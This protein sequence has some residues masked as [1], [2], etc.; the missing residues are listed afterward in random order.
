MIKTP[1]PFALLFL[2][3]CGSDPLPST[4]TGESNSTSPDTEETGETTPPDENGETTPP[5]ASISTG[6]TGLV[7]HSTESPAVL[8]D[9]VT[10]MFETPSTLTVSLRDTSLQD[11]AAPLIAEVS[12]TGVNALPIE[13]QLD[14]SGISLTPGRTYSLSAHVDLDQSGDVSGGDLLNTWSH[15]ISQAAI[16]QLDGSAEGVFEERIH[17]EGI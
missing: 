9:P 1:F 13:Y 11:A 15:P 6:L 5:A 3:S 7:L 8:V 10:W 4:R 14:L 16:G 2:L 17:V 12:L